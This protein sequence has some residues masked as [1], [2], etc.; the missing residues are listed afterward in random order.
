MAGMAPLVTAMALF[1]GTHFLM[2]HPLRAKMVAGL[3][4]NGF[5]IVYSIVSLAT[6]LWAIS[7]YRDAPLG[8][9]LWGSGDGLWWAASVLTLIGSILFVG[10]FIGNP[11]MP[12]PGATEAARSGA[13]GVF[14]ITRHPMMWGFALF[15]FSH[16]LISPQISLIILAVGIIF[17]SLVGS[18][19]Q[20]KKKA[21]TMGADWSGWTAKTS[22]WPFGLQFSGKASWATAYPGRT[23]VLGGLLVWLAITYGHGWFGIA[24]AGLWRWIWG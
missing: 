19:G 15:A 5:Q 8:A 21:V 2:S 18:A 13:R 22:Y 6:L 24:G 14:G 16:I 4:N 1:V 20:D 17:L 10:S 3:G 7:A 23:P 11:A 9:P 12:M